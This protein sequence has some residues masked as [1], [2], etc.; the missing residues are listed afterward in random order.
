[1]FSWPRL[2]TCSVTFAA[3]GCLLAP[4]AI[5]K[6]PAAIGRIVNTEVAAEVTP[7]Q[8]VLPSSANGILV[9]T[10][11]AKCAPES[12]VAGASTKWLIGKESV[13]L[14]AMRTHLAANPKTPVAVFYT[15][16]RRELKRVHAPAR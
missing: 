2:M 10:R 12:L 4:L 13:D 16:D 8:I 14:V 3:M 5:A 9:V 6:P 11:C 7:A 1:M 15:S